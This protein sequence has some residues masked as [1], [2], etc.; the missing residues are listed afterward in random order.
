MA[1]EK[2]MVVNRMSGPRAGAGP[3]AMTPKE[4]FGIL[5]R[6]VF[7]IVFLS[8]LG[9]I[10]GGVAWYLFR[11]KA[12]RYTAETFI[13]VLSP[14]E[15]DPTQIGGP[16]VAKEL[17]Y[18]Y[19]VSIASLIKTQTNLVELVKRDKVLK[20]DWFKQFGPDRDVR[21]QKAVKNLRKKFRAIPHR[22]AEF[23]QLKMTCRDATEAALIVNEMLDLFLVSQGSTERQEVA[24]KL[25]RRQDE[26]ER[27]QRELRAAEDTLT[28]IRRRWEDMGVGNLEG[29]LQ[30]RFEH[31][32]TFRL[33]VLEIEQNELMMQI[34]QL[35]QNIENFRR[36]ATGPI[37]EQVEQIIETDPVMI[38]LRQQRVVQEAQLAGLMTKFGDK[39]RVV[40]QMMELIQE[41]K[42][43]RVERKAEIAEITRQSNLK[44]AQDALVIMMQRMEELARLRDEAIAQ[45]KDLDNARDQ[46]SAQAAIRDERRETRDEI[47][48]YI[49][50]LRMM[51]DDPETPKVERIGYAPVPLEM[52]FPKLTM[53]LPGGT[54]L[55]LLSGLGLAFLVE[56]LND[57]VR[58]PRDVGRYLHIP[59]LGVI[60]HASEDKQV[61]RVDLCHVVRQAPFSVISE[62]YRQFRTNLKLSGP[63][64]ASKALLVSSA[65]PGD[66]KTSV[67]ANLAITFVAENKKVLLMDA[68]F[69]Q[70]RLNKVFPRPEGEGEQGE[71]LD[72]GLSNLLTGQCG[73]EEV[74][75]PSGIDGFDI[76]DT[77]PLPTNPAEL[78]GGAE[79]KDFVKQ[80]RDNYDY[81]IIDGPPV[82]LVSDSKMLAKFCDGT[83]LVFNAGATRRGAAVRTIRELREINASIVG[84]VLFAV[85]AMKGGYFQEQYRSY[86][87]YQ[88]LQLAQST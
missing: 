73:C 70:P 63:A 64:E 83:V 16:Q 57:L 50:T 23:I 53:F 42:L 43:K 8:I 47:K 34:S 55:G 41:T 65:M 71:R 14:V 81:V 84:C 68:N 62:S 31:V 3:A 15:K 7:L 78:L 77:G 60:P 6:H 36:I 2:R 51:H 87:R 20:T 49:E 33:R 59:L 67:A 86:Q 4:V 45:Q 56:L 9:L 54:L 66:G 38:M 76:I 75:R 30:R 12:P 28:G 82:L 13:R 35:T 11:R 29:E 1:E 58:T 69:R 40:R 21:I 79:M 72:V 52:S 25:A 10:A 19:R 26:L 88:K 17:L 5:R 27:V 32:V 48:A 24:N 80:Q 37:N 85:R 44:N 18:G 22:D 46:Y 74:I 61:R 39:H